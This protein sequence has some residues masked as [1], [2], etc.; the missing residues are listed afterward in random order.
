MS[1]A[2]FRRVKS[3]AFLAASRATA[4]SIILPTTSFAKDGFSSNHSLNF[5]FTRLSIAGRT[6]DETNLSLV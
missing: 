3:L 4:A 1:I 2:D 6:S 5:S